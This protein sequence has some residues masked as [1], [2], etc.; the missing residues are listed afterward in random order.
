M[1]SNSFFTSVFFMDYR[2]LWSLEARGHDF[3][4]SKDEILIVVDHESDTPC[5][6]VILESEQIQQRRVG[7]GKVHHRIEN[8]PDE[9]KREP[10]AHQRSSLTGFCLADQ[11]QENKKRDRDR[12]SQKPDAAGETQ[13]PA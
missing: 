9:Q 11:I 12:K 7:P 3:L 6:L 4:S 8:Y 2:S 1:R 5:S 13:N 10:R